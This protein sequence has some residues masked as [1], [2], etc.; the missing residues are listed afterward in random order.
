MLHPTP[1][2]SVV[3]LEQHGFPDHRR[4]IHFL[5][6]SCQTQARSPALCDRPRRESGSHLPLRTSNLEPSLDVRGWWGAARN[7]VPSP[8]IH[9][10]DASTSPIFPSW[11][12]TNGLLQGMVISGRIV[13]HWDFIILWRFNRATEQRIHLWEDW[14]TGEWS[15]KK[16]LDRIKY[17]MTSGQAA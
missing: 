8:L 17:T 16:R 5:F 6:R 14:N 9:Y 2:D 11:S 1:C 3:A 7:V 13:K 10:S 12:G 15:C 4:S